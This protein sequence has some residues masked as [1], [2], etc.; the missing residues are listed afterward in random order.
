MNN[1]VDNWILRG[2]IVPSERSC[3]RS[4][5]TTLCSAKLMNPHQEHGAGMHFLNPSPSFLFCHVL[6]QKLN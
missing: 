5:G 4:A 3:S 1:K 2:L 6:V